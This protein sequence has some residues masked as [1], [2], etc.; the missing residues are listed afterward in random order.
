LHSDGS[1]VVTWYL[2]SAFAVHK[3]FRSHNGAAMALGTGAIQSIST[4]QKIDTCSSTEAEFVS[5]DGIV[6]A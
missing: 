2:D 3:D 5:I 1:S 6:V 4:K